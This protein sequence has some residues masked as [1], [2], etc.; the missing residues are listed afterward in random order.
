MDRDPGF[1]SLRDYYH[2]H[3]SVESVRKSLR[4]GQLVAFDPPSPELF[5]VLEIGH[6]NFRARSLASPDKEITP[7]LADLVFPGNVYYALDFDS[8]LEQ[9]AYAYLSH[10]EDLRKKI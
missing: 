9:A 10:Y 3:T 6:Y 2:Q 5:I 4:V 8:A 1:A 7:I